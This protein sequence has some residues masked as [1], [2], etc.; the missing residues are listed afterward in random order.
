MSEI[1]NV[2]DGVITKELCSYCGLCISIC[3]RNALELD[4]DNPIFHEELCVNCSLC[5][6]VCPKVNENFPISYVPSK[7]Y[8]GKTLIEDFKKH[9][10][11]GGVV[12]TLAFLVLK[13]GFVDSVITTTSDP[14]EP[15]RAIPYVLKDPS[16]VIKIGKSRYCY[17]PL[18]SHLKEVCTG[19]SNVCVVGLPC[20]L[21]GVQLTR[22][23][24]RTI[25]SKLK[26]L[27]GLLCFNN[28]TYTSLKEKILLESFN[29]N[30]MDV[31][32]VNIERGLFEVE[33]SSG[34]IKKRPVKEFYKLVRR[35]CLNCRYFIPPTCDI[36]VGSAGAPKG[37]SVILVY[38][39][40]GEKLL[41]EAVDNNLMELIEASDKTLKV[42]KKLVRI[43]GRRKVKS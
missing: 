28:F 6:K 1:N 13:N 32:R 3:P 14:K 25:G 21:N 8:I 29:V 11:S 34:E 27:I 26:L 40:L 23:K 10:Q 20:Q 18:L 36:A 41:Q 38:S 30:P 9:S 12:T 19:S 37:Y 17:C 35:A 16:D 39:E 31:K 7:V 15:Q 24:F 43:K 22:E 5:L 33:L 4:Y 2:F 42:L